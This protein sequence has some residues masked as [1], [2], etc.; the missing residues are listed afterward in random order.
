MDCS[1]VALTLSPPNLRGVG[2]Y[3]LPIGVALHILHVYSPGISTRAPHPDTYRS[4]PSSLYNSTNICI[5]NV[6]G[7][8]DQTDDNVHAML[9]H[10][11]TRPKSLREKII[12]IPLQ[13]SSQLTLR[14]PRPGQLCFTCLRGRFCTGFVIAFHYLGTWRPVRS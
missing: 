5:K 6:I 3:N 4:T 1:Y 11:V 2:M 9:E 14:L 12:A 13:A 7:L 10:K 8:L